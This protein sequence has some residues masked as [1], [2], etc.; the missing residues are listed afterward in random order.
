MEP[1]LAHWL[2]FAHPYCWGGGGRFPP[3]DPSY[4][5]SVKCMQ[6]YYYPTRMRRGKVIGR[7]VIVVVVVIVAVMDTKVAK[8][9]DV[10]T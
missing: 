7:A 1:Q 2:P 10:R 9:G 8:S 3:N 6:H 5:N 4:C